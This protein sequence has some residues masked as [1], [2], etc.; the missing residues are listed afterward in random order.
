MTLGS[1]FPPKYLEAQIRRQ[2]VPGAVIKLLRVM[3]DGQ[4]HEKR[5]VV[6]HVDEQT[7]AC[8]I[9]SGIGP[10][11]RVRPHLLRCQVAMLIKSHSFMSNDSHVDCSRVRAFGT[12]DVLRDLVAQP[13]WILG[14]ITLELRDEIVAALKQSST[15]SA[16]E[17]TRLC[18]SLASMDRI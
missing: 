8:V 7:V 12:S 6:L 14:S 16:V 17:V 3:D 18:A 1:A 4:L 9:N 13:G 11:I 2:L 10:F 5:F 15:I